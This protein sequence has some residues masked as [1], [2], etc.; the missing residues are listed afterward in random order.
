[1]VSS[2]IPAPMA[3]K[4]RNK[5]STRHLA[6]LSR[7]LALLHVI[8]SMTGFFLTLGCEWHWRQAGLSLKG[9]V[10]TLIT[11]RPVERSLCPPGW[12]AQT[13]SLDCLFSLPE[14]GFPSE[15]GKIDSCRLTLTYSSTRVA[16]PGKEIASPGILK[17]KILGRVLTGSV[18]VPYPT[19]SQTPR[20]EI[21]CTVTGGTWVC[22]CD[23]MV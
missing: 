14:A 3:S 19:L 16:A 1:M 2:W 5:I 21:W 23:I 22:H 20:T 11:K 15:V 8:F 18:W 7:F 17:R 6:E 10:L 12:R 13:M 9:N 4:V